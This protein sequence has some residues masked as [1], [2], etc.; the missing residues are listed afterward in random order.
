M[1][2]F[3]LRNLLRNRRRSLITLLSIVFAALLTSFAR[4]LTYGMA[5]ETFNQ[6]LGISTG[7]LQIAAF[8]WEETRSIERALD[9]SAELDQKIRIS[10][11]KEV[12][13]HIEAAALLSAGEESRFVRVVAFDPDRER[14]VTSLH[15]KLRAG[16]YISREGVSRV[17]QVVGQTP[18]PVYQAM[19]GHRM[20]SD[21]H[22][23]IGQSITLVGSH[24]DGSVGAIEADVVGL[25]R[26][27][28]ALI[29]SETVFL[30]LPAG[31]AL[32]APG[33]EK[34]VRY[35]NLAIGVENSR[36]ADRIIKDLSLIFPEPAGESDPEHSSN[37]S[38]VVLSWEVLNQDLVQMFLIKKA[39][40]EF[41]LV[42]LMLVMAFGVL[43]TVEMSLQER[44]RE[45]G[46]L[47]AI[48]TP[49][50]RL[51]S[52]TMIEVA[53]VLVL[54]SALGLVL[55]CSAGY[56]LETHPI[57][58]TGALAQAMVDV[59]RIPFVSAVV[60]VSTIWV[61]LLTIMLPSAML[62]YLA[63]RRIPKMNPVQAIQ[64]L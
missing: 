3:A 11:V 23:Q 61:S 59:G 57:Q 42:F 30:S 24:F 21:L 36:Q 16:D 10:G 41:M 20:A 51:V 1:L 29:D 7:Y 55:G 8:G 5:Q 44:T 64:T 17:V 46:I 2:Q 22:L 63:V 53:V 27:D 12:S 35:T 32:F 33:D 58:L 26:A 13:P 4:F 38:P 52:Q 34:P 9:W 60:D 25:L 19:I 31:E 49:P 62:S 14:S 15:R 40:V 47:L 56:Y 37:Y 43:A 39:G 54:G 50:V 18:R 48:G 6:V 45:F 28:Y